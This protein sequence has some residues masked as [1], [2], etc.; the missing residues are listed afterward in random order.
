MAD[1]LNLTMTHPELCKEWHPTK[2]GNLL[3][4]MVS[5][6]T[7]RL[8]WWLYPYNIPID[9]PVEYLRGKHINFEWETPVSDRT[10]PNSNGSCPFIDW[11]EVWKGFNDLETV[12]PELAIQ[13]DYEANKDLTDGRGYDISTPDK[14]TPKYIQ[15]VNWKLP[16]DVPADY[17]VE[18]LRGKHFDFK[19]KSRIDIRTK[20]N[21]GC[22][23]LSGH[24]VWKGF[25]DLETIYPELALQ[26]D[27]RANKGLKDKYD[28]DISTPDKILAT[29]KAEVG[30][31]YHYDVPEDYPIKCL[32][33]KHFDFKW[34]APLCNRSKRGDGCPFLTGR[35]VW[36]GFNDLKTVL[37]DLA[38]QWHPTKNIGLKDKK[39]RDIS[40][41]DKVTMYSAQKVWWLL[42][43]D[44]PNDYPFKQLRGKHFDFEWKAGI[45]SR[46][47]LDAMCPFLS[48]QAVW[49]GFNDLETLYPE[50]AKQWHPI[51]NISLTDKRGRD[52]STPDKVT[53]G[54]KQ[55]IWWY[56]PYDDP[57]TGEHFDFEW[58]TAVNNRTISNT[59]CPFIFSSKG[60]K[61]IEGILNSNKILFR[62]QHTFKDRLYK[63]P[64]RDDFA[65]F[66]KHGK[67]VGTIEFHG[68]QHYKPVDFAGK[69]Q[70]W[71]KERFKET[72][73]RDKIKSDYLKAHGIKQL[74]I[75]YKDFDNA[76]KIV[77]DFIEELSKTYGLSQ[78]SKEIPA[79]QPPAQ[80]IIT[81][82]EV[83]DFINNVLNG[84]EKDKTEKTNQ[85]L[86]K[87]QRND[88][89]ISI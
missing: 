65:I 49:K 2:N 42:P 9:Y 16:Y 60:E 72:Q 13:W 10:H 63:Q 50:I 67:V 12:C 52:I 38:E 79:W 74:I 73:I 33:G 76:E 54:S 64:L 51:K 89:D 11:R 82:K 43:Y 26:W 62:R 27:Y 37:P 47:N 85:N 21:T 68:Q 29:S 71:A 59:G 35:A 41:P 28:R 56:L 36:K 23:F 48:G 58:K 3:P 81:T 22:P 32:R 14:V 6:G 7:K 69:G 39:G 77:G 80:P 4:E 5:K 70:E 34:K 15:E 87:S 75:S 24:A 86:I 61:R 57:E 19:W 55:K 66:D 25:N 53:Y 88:L 40:T 84:N 46:T 17:V 78:P 18:Q 8:V 83:K 45:D 31:I 44:V 1:R 20:Y 30:W